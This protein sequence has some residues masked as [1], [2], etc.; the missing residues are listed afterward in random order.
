MLNVSSREGTWWRRRSIILLSICASFICASFL[1][2]WSFLRSSI[3]LLSRGIDESSFHRDSEDTNPCQT[4]VLSL[5]RIS[6]ILKLIHQIHAISQKLS[7]RVPIQPTKLL[8]KSPEFGDQALTN[9]TTLF[10]S[11]N[12]NCEHVTWCVCNQMARATS[13]TP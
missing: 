6:N 12:L 8:V 10:C 5:T 2:S 11:Q 9:A 3:I 13:D 7:L 1:R 4:G